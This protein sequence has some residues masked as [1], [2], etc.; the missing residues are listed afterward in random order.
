MILG[1]GLGRDGDTVHDVAGAE[2]SV[3]AAEKA[4]P[5]TRPLSVGPQDQV[6]LVELTPGETEGGL[7]KV[8]LFHFTAQF[9]LQAFQLPGSGQ[10]SP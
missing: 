1:D 6:G 2:R 5:A 8:Y 10:E 4:A 7:V 9:N 3:F